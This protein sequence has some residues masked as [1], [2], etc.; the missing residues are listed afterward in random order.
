MDVRAERVQ[1]V[2]ETHYVLIGDD[3]AELRDN[4]RAWFTPNRLVITEARYG[5]GV[6]SVSLA[7]RGM[8]RSGGHMAAAHYILDEAGVI[9]PGSRTGPA[10]EWLQT[11][12]TQHLTASPDR[13]G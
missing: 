11:L 13:V 5:N 10:P 9:E 12:V 7:V 8:R 3:L 4:V 6:R 1:V 2:T